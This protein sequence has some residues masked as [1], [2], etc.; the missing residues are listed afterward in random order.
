MDFNRFSG[1]RYVHSTR[2]SNTNQPFL[3]ELLKGQVN[4]GVDLCVKSMKKG[5]I[6]LVELT[7]EYGVQS[8]LS[9]LFPTESEIP[10]HG[11]DENLFL[12]IELVSWIPQLDI[13][14]D[15]GVIKRVVQAATNLK[16][17]GWPNDKDELTVSVVLREGTVDGKE[18]D[19]GKYTFYLDKPTEELNQVVPPGAIDAIG[20]IKISEIADIVISDVDSGRYLYHRFSSWYIKY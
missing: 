8:L 12:E 4:K 20:E 16:G 3:F 14:K 13:H 1:V 5:E 9:S 18:K 7:G 10:L 15:G 6:C 2:D 17:L 11:E 19:L